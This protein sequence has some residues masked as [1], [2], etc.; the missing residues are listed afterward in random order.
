MFTRVSQSCVLHF[1]LTTSTIYRSLWSMQKRGRLSPTV[2]YAGI[3]MH[4][5]CSHRLCTTSIMSMSAW[6]LQNRGRLSPIAAYEGRFVHP[7]CSHR[8]CL[9][10]VMSM[11]AWALHRRGLSPATLNVAR[12]QHRS[13]NIGMIDARHIG[14]MTSLMLPTSSTT[15]VCDP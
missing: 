11:S 1:L 8:L 12:V 7:S 6:A 13:Q 10:L 5:T 4:Q 9:T 15:H 14:S 3:F 2:A